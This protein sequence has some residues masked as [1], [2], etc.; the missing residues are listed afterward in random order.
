MFGLRATACSAIQNSYPTEQFTVPFTC[1]ML[2]SEPSVEL[3]SPPIS[4]F[5]TCTA[6]PNPG[7]NR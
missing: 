5:S 7:L 3:A 1:S 4:I 2:G 6:A